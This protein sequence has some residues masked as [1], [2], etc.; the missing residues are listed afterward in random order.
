MLSDQLLTGADETRTDA[1]P[2]DDAAADPHD[3]RPRVPRSRIRP[4]VWA[5][6]AL[7]VI[8]ICGG[9]AVAPV[10][11]AV[12]SF[13]VLGAA[14]FWRS[15][16]GRSAGST[17]VPVAVTWAA[18]GSLLLSIGAVSLQG[19]VGAWTSALAGTAVGSSHQVPTARVQEPAAASRAP[20][21]AGA[22]TSAT[23]APSASGPSASALSATTAKPTADPAS[24][25]VP[26]L[27]ATD[28]GPTTPQPAPTY[29]NCKAVHAAGLPYLVA[30]QPG[31][32]RK[33]DPTGTGIACSTD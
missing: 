20:S 21:S 17:F 8:V 18:V 1:A 29:R 30:G 12:A 26:E 11:V 19:V 27:P 24:V 16:T 14:L 13:I 32:S 4:A 9:L 23:T 7:L 3:R 6:T 10:A 33:L 25:V 2:F 28:A 5:V 15:R 31:Y 22:A